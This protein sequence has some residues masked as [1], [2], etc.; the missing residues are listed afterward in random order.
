MGVER[1]WTGGRADLLVYLGTTRY[2]GP[3]G[4]DRQMA[5]HLSRLGPVLFV[6]PPISPLTSLR[7]PELR[8]QFA[9]PALRVV[10]DGLAVVRPRA[11]PGM[12]RPGLHRLV[13][14]LIRRAV[15][16]AVAELHPG[17]LPGVPVR[18]IV[19]CRGDD[20][21]GAV[22]ARRRVY[23]VKDDFAAGAELLGVRRDRLVR[24]E[25]ESLARADAVATVSPVIRDRLAGLGHRAELVPN[26]CNPALGEAVDDSPPADDVPLPPPIAG[27]VGYVNDRIDLALLEAVAD[28]GVSLL[29]VGLRSP[30]YQTDRFTALAGRPNVCWVGP[31]PYAELP[32]YLRL[33][34]VGLTPYA[35]TAFNRASFPLKTLEYLAAGRPVVSTP[36]PANDWLATD[37]VEVAQG[38]AAFADRVVSLLGTERSDDDV[39]R[40]RAFARL[41]SWDARA[42]ALASLLSDEPVASHR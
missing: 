29:L 17:E 12:T 21:W 2:D 31:R 4:T 8:G 30:R 27:F 42:A 37:L 7:N 15:R 23:F 14:P 36:L 11:V 32:R 19:S 10:R 9:R 25:A 20:V 16:S 1:A 18:G 6:D 5:D 38:P 3:A 22:P 24:Q 13:P 41:H 28:R 35:D 39:A 33:V 34:D 40:R 26:G